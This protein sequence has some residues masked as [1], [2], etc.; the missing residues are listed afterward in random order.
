MFGAA[1]LGAYS[2]DYDETADGY[3]TPWDDGQYESSNLGWTGRREPTRAPNLSPLQ[4]PHQPDFTG[5][6][7]VRPKTESSKAPPHSTNVRHAAEPNVLLRFT[8]CSL[9]MITCPVGRR[10]MAL[11]ENIKA[12]TRPATKKSMTPED[13]NSFCKGM[14]KF[15][16]LNIDFVYWAWKQVL[17]PLAGEMQDIHVRD[18]T[19]VTIIKELIPTAEAEAL[20]ANYINGPAIIAE[21]E[22]KFCSKHFALNYSS[23]LSS[24]AA[25]KD[26]PADQIAIR[27]TLDLEQSQFH[28]TMTD[29]IWKLAMLQAMA[30]EFPNVAVDVGAI[31]T[32]HLSIKLSE[33]V[34]EFICR[35]KE[36]KEVAPARLSIKGRKA[37]ATLPVFA[38]SSTTTASAPSVTLA[39]IAPVPVQ[40]PPT[41]AKP[42]DK[43]KSNKKS[44][45][46]KEREK[47]KAVEEKNKALEAQLAAFQSKN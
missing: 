8:D 43:P 4:T 18:S 46:Q 27:L 6:S 42:T 21:L 16:P 13:V 32:K 37:G 38:E 5:F 31:P 29:P 47:F 26:I 25:Y 33:K 7:S 19:L 44:R 45:W 17:V 3:A 2:G 23:R 30:N 15:D 14:N 12:N 22:N 28:Y 41:T 39:A 40:A 10:V 36:L 1:N 9:I 34:A 20:K 35:I 11:W 24:G